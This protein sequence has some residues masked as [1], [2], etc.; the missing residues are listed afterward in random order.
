LHQ[1]QD[2][3]SFECGQAFAVKSDPRNITGASAPGHGFWLCPLCASGGKTLLEAV[4]NNMEREVG[5]L[6]LSVASHTFSHGKKTT[7]ALHVAAVQN[8]YPIMAKLLYG[9]AVLIEISERLLPDF[10]HVLSPLTWNRDGD[11]NTAFDAAYEASVRGP[12]ALCVDV[13]FLL[14]ARLVNS[15]SHFR[16]LN[17]PNIILLPSLL[18]L[19][20][21]YAR[22]HT[23]DVETRID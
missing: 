1:N 6:L 10:P 21:R 11:G 19:F 14:N 12:G 5:N 13:L 3:G 16:P 20:T 23:G 17:Q 9:A 8:N 15:S 4:Q 22:D 7:T 2:G 18:S